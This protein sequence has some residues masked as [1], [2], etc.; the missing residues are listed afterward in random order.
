VKQTKFGA[1]ALHVCNVHPEFAMFEVQIASQYC[2][3]ILSDLQ[4]LWKF[5][6]EG[7]EQDERFWKKVI[8]ILR[9]IATFK[10]GE[11]Q[12][13]E[14]R[15]EHILHAAVS[16]K[17][18]SCPIEIFKF[19][20]SRYPNQVFQRDSRG[21]LPLHVAVGPTAW[22]ESTR[23]K[24]RPREQHFVSILLKLNPNAANEKLRSNHNRYP[25][26]IALTNR[27]TW[28]GGIQFLLHAAPE[29]DY[30]FTVL[31]IAFALSEILLFF[32]AVFQ[33]SLCLI[34]QQDFVRSSLL[35]F[36]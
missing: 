8:L 34:Q 21:M 30:L 25:L 16:L 17:A 5:R 28:S 9:A 24:Y 27:H 11:M 1:H 14:N 36:Q 12:S 7:A 20:V 6:P 15:D 19:L 18:L 3:A 29:G 23:R 2:C 35:P 32:Y 13:K 22:S 26:H 33:S 10:D 4:V 31:T